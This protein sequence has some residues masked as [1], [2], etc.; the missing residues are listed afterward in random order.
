MG[1]SV[2][3]IRNIVFCGHGNTGKTSLIDL[4][5]IKSGA[6]T[7]HPSVDAGTSICDFDEEEKQH[8]YTIESSSSSI[9]TT[10]L[11]SISR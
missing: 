4:M 8:K 1:I 5:L 10:R 3:D 9:S 11:A 6:A 7:G 2:A